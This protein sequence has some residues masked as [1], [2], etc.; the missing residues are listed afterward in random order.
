MGTLQ[1][2][3]YFF[4]LFFIAPLT[5]TCAD[6]QPAA[7]FV[8]IGSTPGDDQI[9]KLLKIPAS[10]PID[11]ISW[12]ISFDGSNNFAL[13]VQFGISQPNT[14]GFKADGEK[15]TINGKYAIT[16]SIRSG[17]LLQLQSTGLSGNILIK[18]INEN[19]FHFQ[20]ANG[21]LMI[22]N[23]GWSYSLQRKS[24]T[25]NGKIRMRS[26]VNKNDTAFKM[27]F[28][29]RTPCLEIAREHVEM[30]PNPDCFKIK[31]RLT[32]R[33]DQ[34][35]TCAIRNI[36]DEQPR[37]IEGNWEI[38]KEVSGNVQTCF[39]RIK[40]PN[41]SRPIHFFIADDNILFFVDEHFIPFIGNKN[42]SYT[43]N[44]VK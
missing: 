36:V 34:N 18:Q 5:V 11:F 4:L 26:M 37:D 3:L 40:V 30:K 44:R 29:G 12:Q 10:N 28:D 39:Y 25:V 1:K 43:M 2:W 17:N 8:L 41:L 14:L 7:A 23:G 20:D 32:L 21:G 15:R 9:K 27:V 24:L 6:R 42:F 33:R 35:Q 13:D 38:I 16:S 31:W 22:G 19:L